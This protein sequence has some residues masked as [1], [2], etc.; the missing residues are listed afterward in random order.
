MTYVLA[1]NN[2]LTCFSDNNHLTYVLTDNTPL[3]Y[4]YR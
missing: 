3:T 4:V 1:D 2:T